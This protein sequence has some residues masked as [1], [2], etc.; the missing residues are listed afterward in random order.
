MVDG[1]EG[2][3]SVDRIDSVV[4]LQSSA[5]PDSRAESNRPIYPN[6]PFSPYSSP[7]A[8]P[9]VKR[10]PLKMTKQASTEQL[11]NYLQL[12][13]YKLM[14]MV[15]QGS[16]SIVKLAYN[17]DEDTHYVSSQ[18]DRQVVVDVDVSHIAGNENSL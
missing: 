18:S 2:V 3:R 4:C 6:L 5:A 15:G 16:Y 17:V 13:Q 7:N 12:N 9:R 10:R 1:G 8:S 11:G 14:G